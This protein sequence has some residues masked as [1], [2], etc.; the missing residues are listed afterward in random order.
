MP[1]TPLQKLALAACTATKNQ[2]G[3]T[4]FR[5]LPT[6]VKAMGVNPH[7]LKQ[8]EKLGLLTRADGN[9]RNWYRVVNS[10]SAP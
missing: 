5:W 7:H 4:C 1:L 10:T 6:S 8:L 3:D 2:V 9:T